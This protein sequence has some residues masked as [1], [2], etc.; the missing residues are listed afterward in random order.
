M[1]EAIF[2]GNELC[3]GRTLNTNHQNIA[4]LFYESG[5]YLKQASTVDDTFD[6][7]VD[8]FKQKIGT[9]SV[10]ITTGGLG[11]TQ[12]DRTSAAIAK[13]C[14][15]AL[16]RNK[17]EVTKIE[18]YFEKTNRTM[19]D[20]NAKQA[21]FPEGAI[22][23]DNPLGTAPGFYLNHHNTLIFCCPGV[24]KEVLPMISRVVVPTIISTLPHLKKDHLSKLF[25][26]IGI[27]ESHCQ[28]RLAGIYP[29]PK[30]IDI[31]FQA[32]LYEIQIRLTKT[33]DIDSSIFNTIY[34]QM[35]DLLADVCFST[36]I[37]ESLE[38]SIIALCSQH[39]FKLSIA[40]SCT[41]GLISHLLTQVPGASRVI[42]IN[43]VTYSNKAKSQW[44]NVD[45]NTIET[46][47]AVSSE[48]VIEMASRAKKLSNSTFAISVSGIAGPTGGTQEKPVGTVYFGLASPSETTAYHKWFNGSRQHVQRRSAYTALVY[49]YNEIKQTID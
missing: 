3:D 29:L 41:G 4:R 16:V 12:D 19:P 8:L 1:I 9:R 46:Y 2:I 35:T 27:G 15:L 11:P 21:D 6:D 40:E 30:G 10:I 20:A 31:T 45:D 14:D 26:C 32:K 18:H 24:P 28:E 38:H 42:D 17:H 44:L 23:M 5:L 25:K 22:I 36:S 13:A 37:D 7:L 49:L 34:T 47:G 39:K 43:L 33:A 48:V